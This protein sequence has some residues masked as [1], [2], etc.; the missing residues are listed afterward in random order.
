[1]TTAS[2]IDQEIQAI[3]AHTEKNRDRIVQFMRDICAIPSPE[4]WIKDVAERIGGEMTD[5]GF[6]EV[7][8]DSMGNIL[9][10]V[11]SGPRKILFDSHIDTVGL[12]NPASWQW[13]PF[14]GKVED[15][16]LFARGACDEKNSTPGMVYALAMWKELGLGEEFTG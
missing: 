5:L 13:D 3:R 7:F 2:S 6:D 9:G 11:G 14:H 16:V 10:R 12:G 1:M 15:G 8:Y 4:G